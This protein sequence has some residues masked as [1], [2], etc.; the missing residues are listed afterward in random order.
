[1]TNNKV[2]T[3]RFKRDHRELKTPASKDLSNQHPKPRAGKESQNGMGS[4]DLG[5]GLHVSKLV[6]EE[7]FWG[8]GD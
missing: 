7:H 4:L 8:M 5:V 6:T 1:M 2:V 3:V